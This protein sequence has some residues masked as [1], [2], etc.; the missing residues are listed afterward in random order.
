MIAK[1]ASLAQS[2]LLAARQ[3]EFELRKSSLR[4]Y[5]EHFE[6]DAFG[7]APG[8]CLLNKL[9]VSII[10]ELSRQDKEEEKR[11]CTCPMSFSSV[12]CL[13]C[14]CYENSPFANFAVF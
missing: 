13:L 5:F 11:I 8:S 12:S 3:L 1:F 2:Q 14:T 6:Y 7:F 9:F 10:K 4:N